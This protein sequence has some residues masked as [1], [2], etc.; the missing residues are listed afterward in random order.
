MSANT[1]RRDIAKVKTLIT[2]HGI[3]KE[4]FAKL[5]PAFLNARGRLND[6]LTVLKVI[7]TSYPAWAMADSQVR[8]RGHRISRHNFCRLNDELPNGRPDL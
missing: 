5:V 4:S 1:A 8:R 3:T 7:D 2:D 6:L